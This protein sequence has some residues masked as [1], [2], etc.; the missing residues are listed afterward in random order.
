MIIQQQRLS[1]FVEGLYNIL[2]CFCD[3]LCYVL[4]MFKPIIKKFDFCGLTL[5]C[6][7][8][9]SQSLGF[10]FLKKIKL[11][12]L[13]GTFCI[14]WLCGFIRLL[15]SANGIML[16]IFTLNNSAFKIN[17]FCCTNGVIHG[18][19]PFVEICPAIA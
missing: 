11:I 14:N 3:W 7:K 1:I 18:C 12:L 4:D 16:H 19:S 17:Y 15:G 9:Y 6:M 13:R 8:Y 10:F 5:L 2:S